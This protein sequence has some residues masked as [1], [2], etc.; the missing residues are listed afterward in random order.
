MLNDETGKFLSFTL[1]NEIYCI[2]ILRVEEIRGWEDVRS[3]PNTPEYMKGVLNFRGV[4]VP[5]VELRVRFGMESIEYSPT[6]VTIVLSIESDQGKSMVGIVVDGVSDVLDIKAEDVLAAPR[7]GATINNRF[8]QGVTTLE[9]QMVVLL[10]IDKIFNE[11]E[12][13]ELSDLSE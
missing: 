12:L 10:D 8:V 9:G 6:T 5:I 7:I 11:N 3:L 2:D 4:V 1:N 13:D